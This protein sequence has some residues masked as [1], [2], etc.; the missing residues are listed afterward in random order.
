M[1]TLHEPI[2]VVGQIIPWNFP[3]LMFSWKVAPA[4][5]CGN[6]IILKTAEQTPLSAI[7]ASKL[8]HE[9]DHDETLLSSFKMVGLSCVYFQC[10]FIH[11]IS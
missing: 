2:G 6:T 9:V 3:L 7:L 10:C 11:Q 4:L 5:A 8:L 1:Q